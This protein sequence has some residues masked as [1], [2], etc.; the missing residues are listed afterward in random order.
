MEGSSPGMDTGGDEVP[1][2]NIKRRWVR[3]RRKKEK[4][5]DGSI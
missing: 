4:K 1:I 5:G 3:F 2:E